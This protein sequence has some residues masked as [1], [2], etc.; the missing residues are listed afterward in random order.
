MADVRAIPLKRDDMRR[1]LGLVERKRHLQMSLVDALHG[2]LAA[3]S[4]APANQAV[5]NV[6]PKV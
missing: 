2:A 3:A 6:R 4:T 5:I 1:K